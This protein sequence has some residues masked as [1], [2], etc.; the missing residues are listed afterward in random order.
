M[1]HGR[2]L[3]FQRLDLSLSLFMLVW[4][5]ALEIN[6]M[7]SYIDLVRNRICLR[8]LESSSLRV[9]GLESQMHQQKEM[10]N[11]KLVARGI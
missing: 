6:N 10:R 5:V 4:A 1:R 2:Y 3:L 11:N 9:Y 7:C 8:D